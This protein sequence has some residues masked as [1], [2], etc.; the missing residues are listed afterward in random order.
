ML[1]LEL[2]K[3]YLIILVK[4][5]FFSQAKEY[6]IQAEVIDL[7]ENTTQIMEM[8]LIIFSFCGKYHINYIHFP[9]SPNTLTESPNLFSDSKI[10]FS[11][12]KQ[13]KLSLLTPK[14]QPKIYPNTGIEKRFDNFLMGSLQ[15]V[16]STLISIC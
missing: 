2:I 7:L 12:I 16:Y 6:T 13:Q 3:I 11:G 8:N 9:Q 10:V 1:I 14:I 5:I 4:Q 15:Y